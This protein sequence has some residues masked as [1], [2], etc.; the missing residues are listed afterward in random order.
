MK[1]VSKTAYYTAG[2]RMQDAES[3]KSICGDSY[4]KIFMDEEGLRTFDQFRRFHRPNMSN[5]QRHRII[6]DYLRNELNTN[7]DIHIFLI[8]AGFDSRAYRLEGG[9]WIEVDEPQIINYKERCLPATKCK[10]MLTRVPIDFAVDS[11]QE[12]LALFKRNQ[13]VIVVIE[14]VFMYLEEEAIHKLLRT[15]QALFPD[16][17]LICD[18]MSK[19]FFEKYGRSIHKVIQGMGASFKFTVDRP[20]LFF[21]DKGYYLKEKISIIDRAIRSGTLKIP[22]FLVLLFLKTLVDGYSVCIFESR[23]K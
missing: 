12:K 6:D 1:P 8:G 10:N 14:G 9:T 20:E 3:K 15:L 2:I 18:L 13:P 17:S 4:A 16:H 22:R 5:L 11:L 23:Q 7:S 19:K 21:Q